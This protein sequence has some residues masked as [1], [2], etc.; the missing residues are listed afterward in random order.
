MPLDLISLIPIW[1]FYIPIVQLYNKDSKLYALHFP[2][3]MGMLLLLTPIY[4][5]SAK[6]VK[7]FKTP[8][9][10]RPYSQFLL[11]FKS[12]IQL[13]LTVLFVFALTASLWML[14]GC[15][16]GSLDFEQCDHP[17]WIWIAYKTKPIK[18]ATHLLVNS[19]YFCM[20]TAVGAGVGDIVGHNLV[21]LYIYVVM[22][23]LYSLL[24]GGLQASVISAMY[25]TALRKEK[26]DKRREEIQ[27][28]MTT[29]GVQ[30]TIRDTVKN[31]MQLDK[32][33][34]F[35]LHTLFG[36]LHMGL[37]MDVLYALC[38]KFFK[39]LNLDCSVGIRRR[40]ALH[41]EEA[42]YLPGDLVIPLGG[43]IDEVYFIV[44]GRV[45]WSKQDGNVIKV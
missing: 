36:D 42:I 17:G 24:S 37:K 3:R 7:Y 44:S 31:Y 45:K 15:P 25:A 11:S 28:A 6:G 29:Y 23:M 2:L 26:S 8:A 1:A 39:A 5:Q 10:C 20:S 41:V 9:Q 30:K 12:N 38:K 19:F 40:L 32:C 14:V 13:G 4:I 22:M 35:R 18:S 27:I 16:N 21:E 33:Y 34:E 43:I